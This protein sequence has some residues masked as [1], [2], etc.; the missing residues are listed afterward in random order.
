MTLLLT[1]L[2][3][4]LVWVDAIGEAESIAE[5]SLQLRDLADKGKELRVHSLLVLLPLLCNL[6]LLQKDKKIN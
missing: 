4:D 3:N 2:E 5:V 6:V 1:H